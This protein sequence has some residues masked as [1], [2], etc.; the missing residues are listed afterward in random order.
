MPLEICLLK[1]IITIHLFVT[2]P[3]E[4]YKII[5]VPL[6]SHFHRFLHFP[7]SFLL[8]SSYSNSEVE[9]AAASTASVQGGEGP[10]ERVG[11]SG[12]HV[13][14]AR[15]RGPCRARLRRPR[16]HR[17][18]RRSCARPR[19]VPSSAD[20]EH[21]ERSGVAEELPRRV[22]APVAGEVEPERAAAAGTD[23][24]REWHGYVA[25]GGRAVSGRGA[26]ENESSCLPLHRSILK[27][28]WPTEVRRKSE[29][30]G[31]MY[32]QMKYLHSQLSAAAA[33]AAR[34]P[35]TSGSSSRWRWRQQQPATAAERSSGPW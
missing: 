13:V 31:C 24:E 2:V 11:S 12:E 30:F 5:T 32:L 3:L 15:R 7:S 4:F 21:L 29:N 28:A 23:A 6:P 19:R 27:A 25:A 14:C 35:H 1:N 22:A 18:Q 17:P 8:P 26:S 20:V 33:A 16:Q 34:R 10:A 9:P